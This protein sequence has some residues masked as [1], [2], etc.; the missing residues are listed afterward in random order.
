MA[1]GLSR[2]RSSNP[3]GDGFHMHGFIAGFRDQR[4]GD[5]APDQRLPEAGQCRWLVEKVESHPLPAQEGPHPPLSPPPPP[6][7]EALPALLAAP[8]LPGPVGAG[9]PVPAP[10]SPGA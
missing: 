9:L 2:R 1:R 5:E 6:V 10:V 3:L 8:L 4:L 7:A